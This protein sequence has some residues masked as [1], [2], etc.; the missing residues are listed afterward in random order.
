MVSRGSAVVE[1]S[2]L[3]VAPVGGI[4]GDSGWLS[5]DVSFERGASVSLEDLSDLV[6]SRVGC[7]WSFGLEDSRDVWVLGF[8]DDTV[9][10]DVGKTSPG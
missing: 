2:G 10:L 9:V 1:G 5:L 4:D 3:V 6:G 8:S 7:A